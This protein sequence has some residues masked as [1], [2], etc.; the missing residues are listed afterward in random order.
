MAWPWVS[1]SAFAL[2]AS[3]A[4]FASISVFNAATSLPTA[5]L[6]SPMIWSFSAINLSTSSVLPP[7]AD[8]WDRINSSLSSN[9]FPTGPNIVLSKMNINAKNSAAM[10]GNVKLKSNNLPASACAGMVMTKLVKTTGATTFADSNFCLREACAG[11]ATLFACVFLLT[12]ATETHLFVI[13]AIADMFYVCGVDKN[14]FGCG[15]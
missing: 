9:A 2:S 13:W 10:I 8:N 3:A 4:I 12:D 15:I 7:T 6:A 11:C 14:V 1:T 5:A